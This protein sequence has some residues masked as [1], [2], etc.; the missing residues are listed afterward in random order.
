[1]GAFA[2]NFPLSTTTVPLGLIA[3]TNPT[4]YMNDSGFKSRH[5][6]GANFLMGDGTVRFVKQTINY[7]VYNNVG[8][9]AG[10]EVVSA[11]QL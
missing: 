7:T 6:G 8:S 1:M 2:Q 4:D 5:S 11:D 9:A 3:K 10:G